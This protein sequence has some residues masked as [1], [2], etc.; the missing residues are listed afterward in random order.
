LEDKKP[1]IISD[2][3]RESLCNTPN[4]ICHICEERILD[5]KELVLDHDHLS[6]NLRQPNDPRGPCNVRGV[7]HNQCNLAYTVSSMVP[8]VLQNGSK[9]DFRFIVSECVDE[10]DVKKNTIRVQT[11][12]KRKQPK[13]KDSEDS[14][15]DDVGEACGYD[16]DTDGDDSDEGENEYERESGD[17]DDFDDEDFHY[18]NPYL[19]EYLSE[20]S[21]VNVDDDKE[22]YK[23][24]PRTSNIRVLA[25]SVENFISFQVPITESLSARFIDSYRF[26]SNSLA[27]MAS[28][29]DKKKMKHV[30]KFFSTDEEFEIASQKGV[31]PYE[32]IVD[33]SKYADDQQLPPKESF[34]SELTGKHITDEEYSLAKKAWNVFKCKSLGEYNDKYLLSDVLLLA[35]IFEE[36]RDTSHKIYTLDPA[37]T[38]SAPSLSFNAMLKTMKKPIPLLTDYEMQLFIESGVRGGFCNVSTRHVKANNRYMGDDFDSKQALADGGEKYLSYF[39]ANNL[40][41]FALS[42][43]LPYSDFRWKTNERE[44]ENLKNIIQ[45][46]PDDNEYGAILECDLHIPENLHEKFADFP[47]APERIAL[48]SKKAFKPAKLIATLHDKKKYVV[49]YRYLK[50]M[51]R[52]GVELK[53][54]HRAI[55]FKQEPWMRNYITLN[56]EL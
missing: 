45:Y 23:S 38:Y 19:D 35:D 42:Q 46:I 30:R 25:T 6:T 15:D 7:A 49:H 12:V 17:D 54:V 34:Y 50:S 28:L 18:P 47:F 1:I 16:N 20:S 43:P 40:Y 13:K 39:D 29:L 3:E 24:K 22:T 9:Y 26:L 56:T 5:S 41:G 32:Y 55:S 44:L 10:E 2:E 4:P 36:F 53:K 37:H 31:F 11:G 33:F 8:V 21:A 52:H 51:L 27:A 48:P 14:S